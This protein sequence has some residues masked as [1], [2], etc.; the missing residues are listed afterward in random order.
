MRHRGYCTWAAADQDQPSYLQMP[1][2]CFKKRKKVK[3]T[4]KVYSDTTRPIDTDINNIASTITTSNDLYKMTFEDLSPPNSKSEED[5]REIEVTEGITLSS[6]SNT[7]IQMISSSEHEDV[8]FNASQNVDSLPN[9]KTLLSYSI[10]SSPSDLSSQLTS[11]E[12]IQQVDVKTK[13]ESNMKEN[14]PYHETFEMNHIPEDTICENISLQS[15]V[16]RDREASETSSNVIE[17]SNPITIQNIG[18]FCSYSEPSLIVPEQ[19]NGTL[20]A[21]QIS[22]AIKKALVGNVIG[23]VQLKIKNNS[24]FIPENSS[25]VIENEDNENFIDRID[26]HV[27]NEEI[28]VESAKPRTRS[29]LSI[30]KV[31]KNLSIY[32]DNTKRPFENA[33]IYPDGEELHEKS[34]DEFE[35]LESRENSSTTIKLTVEIHCEELPDGNKDAFNIETEHIIPTIEVEECTV[36]SED[37]YQNLIEND[38]KLNANCNEMTQDLQFISV[39]NNSIVNDGLD[40]CFNGNIFG[41]QSVDCYNVV[42]D[43]EK[44]HPLNVT[45]ENVD[46]TEEIDKKSMKDLI[47]ADNLPEKSDKFS[48][49]IE[50]TNQTIGD[51]LREKLTKDKD[52]L[53]CQYI[54][55]KNDLESGG[56]CIS[57]ILDS[58]QT[59]AI[60][61]GLAATLESSPIEF[62]ITP[63]LEHS[64]Y[65][66]K[67][68]PKENE[69]HLNGAISSNIAL[70]NSITQ[71]KM[72]SYVTE[73]KKI[74]PHVTTVDEPE[75][76]PNDYQL[77]NQSSDVADSLNESENSEEGQL[78]STS[79][80]LENEKGLYDSIGTQISESS[81]CAIDESGNED[82]NHQTCN[83]TS[84]VDPDAITICKWENIEN[85]KFLGVLDALKEEIQKGINLVEDLQNDF[86]GTKLNK[87]SSSEELEP[88][89]NI[90]G[91]SSEKL[92]ND[93][94][95]SAVEEKTCLNITNSS[96][97]V[98]KEQCEGNSDIYCVQHNIKS[99]RE[100]TEVEFNDTPTKNVSIILEPDQT[101]EAGRQNSLHSCSKNEN[102]Y[103][104]EASP[105]NIYEDKCYINS[106][107]EVSAH[108][109]SM[110]VQKVN[111]SAINQNSIRTD[112]HNIIL[113][114]RKIVQMFKDLN[115][116]K[117]T[118]LVLSESSLFKKKHQ[119]IT[120]NGFS[121]ESINISQLS[122]ESSMDDLVFGMDLD[123]FT[124]E[125]S[126]ILKSSKESCTLQNLTNEN[127]PKIGHSASPLLFPLERKH[128]ETKQLNFL[129]KQHSTNY[130]KDEHEKFCGVL[131]KSYEHE[132]GYREK[133][134]DLND[135]INCLQLDDQNPSRNLVSQSGLTT[136]NDICPS[137]EPSDQ[138]DIG[139][140]ANEVGS[141]SPLETNVPMGDSGI[142]N[143]CTHKHEATSELETTK[144]RSKVTIDL[145][146]RKP[147]I[148][149]KCSGNLEVCIKE[150]VLPKIVKS[151][152]SII[153]VGPSVKNRNKDC[154]KLRRN[155][156]ESKTE[157]RHVQLFDKKKIE[158]MIQKNLETFQTHKPNSL[159]PLSKATNISNFSETKKNPLNMKQTQSQKSNSD[160]LLGPIPKK[161]NMKRGTIHGTDSVNKSTA[162][163]RKVRSQSKPST[164]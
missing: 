6:E 32:L 72:S 135:S 109:E 145:S 52:V 108:E 125:S 129:S 65:G 74:E 9:M 4:I 69:K 46:V 136:S 160:K 24:D 103:S 124:S 22:D 67:T 121:A 162:R 163:Y 55:S 48:I 139:I 29:S 102:S 151:P 21:D 97:C 92:C 128:T 90:V 25:T 10:L 118:K 14:S 76:P 114:A 126:P 56:D 146:S 75:N 11:S 140:F 83:L 91:D 39:Q 61:C 31:E 26:R 101:E 158:N 144:P 28:I 57:T 150:T 17:Y 12:S 49:D 87:N 113:R 81:L 71:E 116:Q 123:S 134:D 120:S 7:N 77:G 37:L 111:K 119:G 85:E 64:Y 1:L 155:A 84:A 58:P 78:K 149:V 38:L 30:P 93:N 40:N 157:G 88:I 35:L 98:E 79:M 66:H 122:Y 156:E 104:K 96:E 59:K 86:D 137:R 60:P 100:S 89:I 147:N 142:D 164:E 107:S 47:Q 159:K 143:C 115:Y 68:S 105:V 130:L 53:K 34:S 15:T 16:S 20:N 110:K 82:N 41:S 73:I 54:D 99:E 70:F 13:T 19:A 23:D 117:S 50:I 8:S 152:E 138:G 112:I 106:Y 44:Y 133:I 42:S 132:N 5:L 43:R 148:T 62:A 27:S 131:N 154:A 161:L 95:I 63:R 51:L 141:P 127:E 36:L 3:K 94:L 45:K 18:D 2:I 153:E 33:K 80:A